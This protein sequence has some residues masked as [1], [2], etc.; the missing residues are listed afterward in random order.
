MAPAMAH[1]DWSPSFMGN[2]RSRKK[3]ATK[4]QLHVLETAFDK[5]PQPSQA[6]KAALSRT[7]GMDIVWISDWFGRRRRRSSSSSRP[8]R[9]TSRDSRSSKD[10]SVSSTSAGKFAT[11][12]KRH[13]WTR[14]SS[15]PRADGVDTSTS[16]ASP[17]IVDAGTGDITPFFYR[18]DS[19]MPPSAVDN[20]Q[21]SSLEDDDDD[22]SI[23][24]RVES[25]EGESSSHIPPTSL[26][27]TS[28]NDPPGVQIGETIPVPLAHSPSLGYIPAAFPS[29]G[30]MSGFLDAGPGLPSQ[31]IPRF[32]VV[33]DPVIYRPELFLSP[34]VSLAFKSSEAYSQLSD[35]HLSPLHV[36]YQYLEGSATRHSNF[37]GPPSS[38]YVNN[39]PFLRQV[40]ASHSNNGAGAS[41]AASYSFSSSGFQTRST[42]IQPSFSFSSQASQ[43]LPLSFKI[44]LRDL[45]AHHNAMVALNQLYDQEFGGF[46]WYDPELMIQAESGGDELLDTLLLFLAILTVFCL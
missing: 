37:G 41:G 19:V 46:E 24:G 38:C 13:E 20:A 33:P 10:P 30:T 29:F 21:T 44:K 42:S 39:D 5:N 12:F 26:A 7:T 45:N 15:E 4:R 28:A 18:F 35:V 6:E 23:P 8:K 2:N 36:Q 9:T 17:S 1:R 16:R 43:S 25:K 34:G 3:F 27:I 40:D 14:Y 11:L 32:Q 22:G 31:G